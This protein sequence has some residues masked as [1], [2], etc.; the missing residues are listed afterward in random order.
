MVIAITGGIATGKTTVAKIFKELGAHYLDADQ[1]ARKVLS[2]GSEALK[3]SVER[4]GEEILLPDGSLNRKRLGSIVFSD[5]TAR[6]DLEKICH[7][8][9]IES[10]KNEIETFRASPCVGKKVLVVEIPLLFEC[11]LQSLVDKVVVVTAEQ[12]TQKNRLMNRDSLTQ[13]QAIDR[14]SAQMPLEQKI[15][16]A[17]WI[18][19]TECPTE[20][21]VNQVRRIW[22]EIS[23]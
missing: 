21:I 11:G 18:V 22:S 17:D 3:K 5:S 16:L 2:P 13:Q 12:P 14:I 23:E 8:I 15:Q 1:I 10:L 19:S 20:E 7:P 9:I 4:F 6:N